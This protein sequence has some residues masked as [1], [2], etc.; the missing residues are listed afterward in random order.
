M[1]LGRS[2]F[3]ESCAPAEDQIPEESELP[4]LIVTASDLCSLE[5]VNLQALYLQ[6]LMADVASLESRAVAAGPADERSKDVLRSQ[7]IWYLGND[8]RAATQVAVLERCLCAVQTV[9]AA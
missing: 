2:R 6:P 1:L 7:G 4:L 5:E 8:S 3:N 9:L